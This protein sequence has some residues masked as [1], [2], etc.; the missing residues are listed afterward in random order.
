M[1][2]QENIVENV[3]VCNLKYDSVLYNI[4]CNGYQFIDFGM[5]YGLVV[6]FWGKQILI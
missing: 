3:N 4:L 5:F 2:L 1:L 6:C